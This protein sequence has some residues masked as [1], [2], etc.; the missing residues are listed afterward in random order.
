MTT[1]S[2]QVDTQLSGDYWNITAEL[3]SGSYLPS[4]IFIYQNTGTTT[5]GKYK[6]ICG[7]DELKRLQVWSGTAIPKFG[8]KFVRYSQAKIQLLIKENADEVIAKMI[9]SV[10]LLNTELLASSNNTKVYTI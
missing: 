5:L 8:N 6:G 3:L 10:K 9:N 2:L 4:D 7:M 1:S